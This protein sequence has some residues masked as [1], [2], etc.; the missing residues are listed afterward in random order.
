MSTKDSGSKSWGST[1]II[2]VF[3]LIAAIILIIIVYY[4]FSKTNIDPYPVSPFKFKDTIQICPAILVRESQ[5]G[6]TISPDQYLVKNTCNPS[7]KG[8]YYAEEAGAPQTSCVATFSGKKDDPATKWV[9]EKLPY[10]GEEFKN[11]STDQNIVSFGNRFYLRNSQNDP[12]ELGGRLL[13]NIFN[14]TLA[15]KDVSPDKSFPVSS[16]ELGTGAGLTHKCYN[17]DSSFNQGNELV[18]YFWPTSQPDLY[19]I[20]LP[21]TLDAETRSSNPS[22]TTQTN[23]GVVTLRPYAPLQKET[24][25]PYIN[26]NELYQNGMLLNSQGK[27]PVGTKYPSPEVFLFKITKV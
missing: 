25:N 11:Q 16:P 23:D 5:S 22:L 8:C 14:S 26:N 18:V 12:S 24:Y 6:K 15:C 1:I 21:G 17:P 9:L 13:M 27:Y 7:C 19:Y 10:T 2:G 20:L 3:I 4:I